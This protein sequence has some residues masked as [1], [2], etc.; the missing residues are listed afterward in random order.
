MAPVAAALP[1]G[2]GV[3]GNVAPCACGGL[4]VAE[5]DDERAILDAVRRH[6]STI[7]HH[8]WSLRE[9]PRSETQTASE[10][11]PR[12]LSEDSDVAR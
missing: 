8:D 11:P 5:F 9:F 7:R 3:I 12:D 4:I 2:H 1:G 10:D 6:Q